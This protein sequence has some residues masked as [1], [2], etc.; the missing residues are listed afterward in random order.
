MVACRD[1]SLVSD[2]ERWQTVLA[3]EYAVLYGYGVVGAAVADADALLVRR[4]QQLH[5]D[6]RAR[7]LEE[8]AK[9]GQQPVPPEPAYQV[10]HPGNADAAKAL[11]ADLEQAASAAYAQLAASDVPKSRNLAAGWLRDSS[12]WTLRWTGRAPELPGMQV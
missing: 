1:P 5:R 2:I 10:K 3:A 7:C 9:A 8:L 12:L 6:H 11:A 4:V